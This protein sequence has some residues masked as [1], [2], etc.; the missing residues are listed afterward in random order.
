MSSSGRSG[1][2]RW[3]CGSVCLLVQCRPGSPFLTCIKAIIRLLF[4]LLYGSIFVCLQTSKTPST[5]RHRL[6]ICRNK[7]TSCPPLGRPDRQNCH[8]NLNSSAPWAEIK[9]QFM[10]GCRLMPRFPF[11]HQVSVKS[12]EGFSSK[13]LNASGSF[14]WPS[15]SFRPTSVNSSSRLPSYIES[16]L[17]IWSHDNYHELSQV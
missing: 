16:V 17:L 14:I 15:P 1:W 12:T 11:G 2:K 6:K 8:M 9:K 5:E 13:R 10:S 4:S 7:Y 3:G